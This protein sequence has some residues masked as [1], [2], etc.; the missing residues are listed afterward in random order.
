MWALFPSPHGEFIFQIIFL[1][2][3]ASSKVSVPSRGIY[4]PNQNMVSLIAPQNRFRPL[5]GNLY[6]K[7]A[8]DY[9]VTFGGYVSVPSRGIYIPNSN[10]R[11]NW[12][13]G[14]GFRPLT[15]NLYSKYLDS[16]LESIS[17]HGFR[18]LTGNLYSKWN[19]WIPCF[20]WGGFP[21]PH[22]EF[23]F[24]IVFSTSRRPWHPCFRPLTGNLYSK[25]W[26]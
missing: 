5:T 16:H 20:H 3:T 22:G 12:V 9:T 14:K 1:W 25:F 7:F 17:H 2:A 6:S 13:V 11:L 23:I 10:E 8:V 18:P 19:P 15:G 26:K 21:S 4:I 24:Q